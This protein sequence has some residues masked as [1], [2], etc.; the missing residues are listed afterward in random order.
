M[1]QR[2]L[3]V[4]G[5]RRSLFMV[6]NLRRMGF[7]V[8]T[9]GLEMEDEQHWKPEDA[10][11]LLFP[12]PF[13][14]RNGCVPTAS[15]LTIHPEDVL[16][17]VQTGIPVLAGKGLEGYVQ[18][19]FPLKRYMNAGAFGAVNAEISAE[20]AVFEAMKRTER[21]LMEMRVLVTGYGLFGRALAKKLR[22]LGAEVWIAAR[23]EE[24]RLLAAEDGM[25]AVDICGLQDVVGEMDMIFNTVPAR[26]L[27]EETLHR[28]KT[29]VW[30]LELASAPYCFDPEQARDLGLKFEV[31]PALPARYAPASAGKA[32]A[33][34]A[35]QLLVE[36]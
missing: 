24:Q 7:Q 19:D 35:A 16:S 3:A 32:L 12:Y 8:Q 20:A 27:R 25:R 4:G 22:M 6:E 10:D 26:I 28:L 15:G 30:I 9:L 13:A 18:E 5:D 2:L 11:A 14:V 29:N 21:A 23:R 36:G 34:A 1:V 31:L 17:R 33:E